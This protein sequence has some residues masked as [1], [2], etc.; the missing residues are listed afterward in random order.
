MY[1]YDA[2]DLSDVSSNPLHSATY[3]QNSALTQRKIRKKEIATQWK[4]EQ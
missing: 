1:N 4:Q 3:L 2:F